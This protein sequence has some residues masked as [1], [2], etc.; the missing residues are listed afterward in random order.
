M[1]PT[2]SGKTWI[3][4]EAIRSVFLKGGRCW[5]ASPL[6]ALTNCQM[7]R[8]RPPFRA[9]QRRHRH[10]RHEGKHRRPH[11]R[12]NHRNPPESALRRHAQR[13][14]PEL[15]SGHPRR[16]PLSR[17]P[18]PR[19]RL[20]GDHDLPP[21]P[22]QPPAALGDHRQR[23]GDRRLARLHPRQALP[24]HPGGKAARPSLPPLPPPVGPSHAPGRREPALRKDRRFHRPAVARP[25]GARGSPVRRDDGRSGTVSPPAGDLFPQIPRR[26]RRGPGN[27]RPPGR[28]KRRT[29]LSWR[30][31]RSSWTAS[32]TSGTTG[33]STIS[34]RP[35]WPPITAD[36]CP[37]GNSSWRR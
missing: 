37:P 21:R 16:G 36:S 11:H 32:P 10:R 27:V 26:M 17:G 19:G 22:D 12:R 5:Y 18:G 28:P 35:V 20:G 4:E 2:G 30:S 14:K 33:S 1:A 34:G 3:A 7:G 6:K 25:P 31:W 8:I 24:G 9:G 23:R 29:G 13:G 15:R